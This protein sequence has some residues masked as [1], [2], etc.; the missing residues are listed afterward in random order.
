[1]YLIINRIRKLF[2]V[3]K[4]LN[5]T[6]DLLTLSSVYYAWVKSTLTYSI[7]LWEFKHNIIN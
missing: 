3:F 1:M 6:L 4:E 7:V 5:L 2:Y